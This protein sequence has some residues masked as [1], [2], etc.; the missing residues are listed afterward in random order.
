MCGVG[1]EGGEEG[2]GGDWE[3]EE[4]ATVSREEE[5]GRMRRIG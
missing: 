2:I 1:F 5:I 3:I 4:G